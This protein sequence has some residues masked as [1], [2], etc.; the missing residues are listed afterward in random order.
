MKGYCGKCKK[1]DECI[2]PCDKILDYINQDQ[3]PIQEGLVGINFDIHD[4][5]D[6]SGHD[7]TVYPN[8]DNPTIL[9][10]VIILLYKDGKS[11]RGISELVP[12][13]RRYIR[14]IIKK[15]KES[16]QL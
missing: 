3:V 6:E 5:Y 4:K 1:R 8:L 9:K 14:Q 16:G 11:Q 12:C 13:S 15:Y 7:K 10:E 2:E